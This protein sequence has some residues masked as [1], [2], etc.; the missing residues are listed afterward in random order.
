M[1]TV[2]EGK[3]RFMKR[4]EAGSAPG[5]SDARNEPLVLQQG[6]NLVN[7]RATITA[8][9]QV[10]GVQVRGWDPQRKEAVVA[11]EP[12]AT[13]SAATDAGVTPVQLAQQVGSPTYVAGLATISDPE[14]AKSAARSLS[15]HVAGG[16]AEV[17]G[18]A[19]GNPALRAGTAVRLAGVGNP[20][21]GR[22][23]LT[24]T[25]HDF[26]PQHGYRTAFVASNTSERSLYGSTTA[27]ADSAAVH[28]VVP[29]VVTSAQD[30]E[31]L[32]RVK[33]KIPWL[34]D[35]YES[36]WARTLQPGAGGG[37]GMGVVPEVGDEVLVAF[38]QGDLGHPYVLG[39]L[40]NGK[41]KPAGGADNVH[42]GDGSVV[43][44]SW[45]SRTGMEMAF[46]E[47]GGAEQF[48]ISTNGGA[49]KVVLKQTEKGI[50]IV[51]EGPVEVTAKQDVKVATAAGNLDLKAVNVQIEAT[52]KLDLKGATVTRRR[53][54]HHR[55][56][57]RR[58][59][60]HQGRHGEDQLM[61]SAARVT[62]LTPHPGV[63]TGPGV[64]TVL[65]GGLPAAVVGDLHTCSFPPPATPH[66]PTPIVPPGCPTVLI[67]G[68]PAARV[69]DLSG[70]GAPILP[71]GCPTVLIGG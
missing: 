32:G 53:L 10:P 28:G 17:E 40:Y 68:K 29:A 25:R 21:T 23:V 30:P 1:L 42:G 71:P 38:E 4:P 41:D 62:D 43:R 13:L 33:V 56:L 66:P 44:R 24:S 31:G 11:E 57:R 50:D 70:C 54:R 51:S 59:D 8:A 69:G 27:G 20:F 16:F 3:L 67:G 55:G 26:S 15:D 14:V 37:R 18:T 58:D 49:Q 7:L 34:S 6:V 9:G 45:V 36:G 35:G 46:L 12:A 60:H 48:V 2:A 65:I 61:P 22:Y 63:I 47:S 19:R 5:G 52:S 39:G 64:P